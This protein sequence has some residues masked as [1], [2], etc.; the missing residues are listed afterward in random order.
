MRR[1]P[2]YSDGGLRGLTLES[3]VY[4]GDGGWIVGCGVLRRPLMTPGWEIHDLLL[5]GGCTHYANHSTIC[6]L[7]MPRVTRD[8]NG[9]ADG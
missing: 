9:L 8:I 3:G 7:M 2:G 5:S 4:I 6:G 1:F